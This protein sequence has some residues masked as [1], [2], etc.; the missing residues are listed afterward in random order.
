MRI[1]TTE[2][3]TYVKCPIFYLEGYRVENKDRKI[4]DSLRRAVQYL[5]SHH[6]ANDE[7]CPF[8]ALVKR[9]NQIW[10]G[11]QRPEDAEAQKLSNEAY[12]VIDKY[13]NIYLDRE[14]DGAYTNWPYAVEIGPHIITGVWPVVLTTDSSIELY[15]PLVQK[16]P[17]A[18]VRDIVVK[19][20]IIAMYLTTGNLP[21]KVTYSNYLPHEERRVNMDSV[22]PKQEWLERSIETLTTIISAIE[23]NVIWGNC[24]V[25]RTCPLRNKC[26]G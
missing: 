17:L 14:Y 20:D 4:V 23:N 15:Y 19:A 26:T 22:Y 10:W 5:Y 11:K 1:S 24:H 12:T 16:Q 21:K 3:S 9:W 25:C 2:I 18:L 7:I 6:M 13:Y 8:N